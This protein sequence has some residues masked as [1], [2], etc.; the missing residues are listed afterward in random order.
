MVDTITQ[1]AF[2]NRYSRTTFDKRLA[3]KQCDICGT[4]EAEQYEIHHV[5]KMKNL[6]GKALWEQIMI[7]KR[8]KTLVVCHDCHKKI[9]NGNRAIRI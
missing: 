2:K 3:A 6:K 9:H 1:I 4:T 5:Q 8:R 7:A